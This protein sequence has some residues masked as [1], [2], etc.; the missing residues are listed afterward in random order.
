M[1]LTGSVRLGEL[2]PL[3]AA[4]TAVGAAGLAPVQGQGQVLG[5]GQ[6]QGDVGSRPLSG[7]RG[8]QLGV[9]RP[10]SGGRVGQLADSGREPEA[11][12]QFHVQG[13][14]GSTIFPAFAEL[15]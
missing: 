11:D 14:S 8:T 1:G 13:Q 15:Q 4:P 9:S 12:A 6:G 5:Q 10:I 2:R 3:S 7:G